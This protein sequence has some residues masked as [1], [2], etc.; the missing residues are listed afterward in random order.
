MLTFVGKSIHDNRQQDLLVY[1]AVSRHCQLRGGTSHSD[2]AH[3][4][5]FQTS[6]SLSILHATHDLYFK[7]L[8]QTKADVQVKGYLSKLYFQESCYTFA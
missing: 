7:T 4:C 3:I 5:G 8:W 6:I 1:G 2:R